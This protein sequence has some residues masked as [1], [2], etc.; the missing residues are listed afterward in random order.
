MTFAKGAALS[1]PSGVFDAS[2]DAGTRRAVD[3]HE[4]DDLDEAAFMA[5][6]REA[7]DLNRS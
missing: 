5:L 4:S 7:V 1:D 6:I 3:V 2:L